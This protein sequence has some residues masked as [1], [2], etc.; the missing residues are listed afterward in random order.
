M[1]V[2]YE[3]GQY[4][5]TLDGNRLRLRAYGLL[6]T[7]DEHDPETDTYYVCSRERLKAGEFVPSVIFHDKLDDLADE[8]SL[9]AL[10]LRGG[11]NP[12]FKKVYS[13]NR[14]VLHSPTG[15]RINHR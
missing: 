2:Q 11:Y 1:L 4:L 7:T 6:I 14:S 8:A 13:K 12:S 9:R 5:G 10:A 15:R 3:D